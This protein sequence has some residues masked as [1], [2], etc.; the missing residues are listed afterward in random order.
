MSMSK[1]ILVID[2]PNECWECP[3]FCERIRFDG[4]EWHNGCNVLKLDVTDFDF[5]E[6]CPLKSLPEKK[7]E[8]EEKINHNDD[9]YEKGWNDCI[10]E[11]L[12][13]ENE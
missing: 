2:T 10:D 1:A 13:E 12:G 4:N 7:K 5:Y 9:F 11:I 3:C 6:S 8:F